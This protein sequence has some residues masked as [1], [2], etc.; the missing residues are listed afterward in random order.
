MRKR[1]KRLL[2]RPQPQITNP[3]FLTLLRLFRPP[4][5]QVGAPLPG[6]LEGARA[7]P[8][9]D[10]GMIPRE[11]QLGHREPAEVPRPRVLRVVEALARERLALD[12]FEAADHARHQTGQRFDQ[13]Q[14]GDLAAGKDEIPER[15]L[16]V[17][18]A[19]QPRPL[20]DSFVA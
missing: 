11:E 1:A 17:E 16:L 18:E 8:S 15:N 12:R 4:G 9:L 10:A 7:A 20:V 6:P 14:S 19:E 3:L 2:P 5:E 13:G